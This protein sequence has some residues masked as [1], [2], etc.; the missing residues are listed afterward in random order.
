MHIIEARQYIKTLGCTVIKS[1][2]LLRKF[3]FLQSV[4][5]Q[6]DTFWDSYWSDASLTTRDY[7][8]LVTPQDIKDLREKASGNLT[9][10]CFKVSLPSI[11]LC[12]QL[13]TRAA[14]V[15]PIDSCSIVL[16]SYAY[17]QRSKA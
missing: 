16:G 10:L 8:A 14:G 3:C 2:L 4:T 13:H 5:T 17:G 15:T 6:D 11:A 9:A 12:W 7:F 1:V